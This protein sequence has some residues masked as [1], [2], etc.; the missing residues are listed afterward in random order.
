MATG[1]VWP[2]RVS[3]KAL[4]TAGTPARPALGTLREVLGIAARTHGPSCCS[5]PVTPRARTCRRRPPWRL[6]P[7]YLRGHLPGDDDVS[8]TS[9][10]A[11]DDGPAV[12]SGHRRQWRCCRFRRCLFR[13][14][15]HGPRYLDLVGGGLA[16]EVDRG[17]GDRSARAASASSGA[18]GTGSAA[19]RWTGTAWASAGVHT[20]AR[21]TADAATTCHI[22]RRARMAITSMDVG[23]V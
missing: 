3:P 4:A 10:A 6:H 13:R 16:R 22:L 20:V 2:V 21:A 8:V 19:G 15:R 11:G 23:L 5:M 7:G 14:F 18:A 1:G 17:H 12:A 9:R